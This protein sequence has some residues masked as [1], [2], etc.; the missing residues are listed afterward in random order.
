MTEEEKRKEVEKEL[1]RQRE[2]AFEAVKFG[3]KVI[4]GFGAGLVVGTACMM[5]PM[6]FLTGPLRMIANIGT[7][8]LADFFGEV[9]GNQLAHRV[10][11]VRDLWGMGVDFHDNLKKGNEKK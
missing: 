4:G 2:S 5:V 3:C 11:N 8:G 1:A 7:V 6:G 9:A 10:D